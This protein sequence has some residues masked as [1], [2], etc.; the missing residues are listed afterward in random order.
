MTTDIQYNEPW[1]VPPSY[2]LLQRLGPR[3]AWAELNRNVWIL[4][5]RIPVAVYHQL[6][7][8]VQRFYRAIYGA[9]KKS[10]GAAPALEIEMFTD[11]GTS[12]PKVYW[13]DIAQCP[14]DERV[15]WRTIPAKVNFTEA[16][17]LLEY[18]ELY[19]Y[20]GDTDSEVYRIRDAHKAWMAT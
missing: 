15:R 17:D 16:A 2:E 9:G 4:E 18:L 11:E 5:P 1:V 19:R 10:I 3:D 8:E 20:T 7:G 14:E 6:P 12:D 13:L